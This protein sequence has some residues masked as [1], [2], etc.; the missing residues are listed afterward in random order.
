MPCKLLEDCPSSDS[1]ALSL[2]AGSAATHWG[3]LTKASPHVT[4]IRIKLQYASQILHRLG[5]LLSRSQDVRD[6][7]HC[8]DRPLVVS[9]GLF[10]G[11]DCALDIADEFTQRARKE[12]SDCTGGCQ[13]CEAY[14]F[15]SRR[16]R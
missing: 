15:V 9:Y 12:V 11:E 14:R 4:V 16:L 8:G 2:L 1:N 7:V 5:K 3:A 13:D 10:V 6:G